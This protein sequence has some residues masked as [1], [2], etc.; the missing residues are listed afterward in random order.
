[1]K[2]IIY[3]PQGVCCKELQITLTDDNKIE[4]LK[5]VGGC[6][7]NTE[8]ISS[9][10]KG[11][12]ALEVASRLEHITCGNKTTSCP[13]QLSIALKKALSEELI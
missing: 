11:Q 4:N 5:F 7:G 6:P 12:D 1:M 2:E 13:A 9:L 10:A 3:N 8:G